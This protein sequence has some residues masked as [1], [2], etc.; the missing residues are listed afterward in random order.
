MVSS[1]DRK[2]WHNMWRGGKHEAEQQRVNGFYVS[3]HTI[4]LTQ[5]VITQ[6]ERN[7]SYTET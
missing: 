1:A 4:S 6:A 3:L 7:G 2:C 5:T